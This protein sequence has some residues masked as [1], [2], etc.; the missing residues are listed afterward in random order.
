[1]IYLDYNATTPIATE[2]AQGIQP[3]LHNDFGNP[4]SDY[5]LGQRAKAGVEGARLQ[6]AELLGCHAGRSFLCQRRHRSQ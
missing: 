3:Y 1:M 4:S 5:S 6:V 2:V